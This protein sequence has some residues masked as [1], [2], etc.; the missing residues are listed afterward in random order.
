MMI[1][2]HMHTPRCGH[3]AGAPSE[4]VAAARR[5]GLEVIAFT[6][7]LALPDGYD[8]D[9]EYAMRPGELGD[10]VAEVRE[11]QRLSGHSPRVLL[12]IEAD[13]VPP[14]R[15]QTAR[16]IASH[17]F[18]VVLGSVHFLGDW[19]FDDPS[20]ID[21]WSLRDVAGA[22]DEYF[23]AFTHAAASG[24]FDVMA[25]PDLVKKFGHVPPGDL[26]ALYKDVAA[27]V[28]DAGVAVEVSS[29]GLRKPCREIYPSDAL[30][31]AFCRAGVPV[32][33]ASDAHTPEEVGSG[34]AEV[35][36]AVERAGY[37]SI[38]YF[39]AREM[40]EVPL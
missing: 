13:W 31:S 1:D 12:G 8:P 27:A 15:G 36:E 23:E 17:A 26:S 18:D 39:E 29:A 4:Y 20:L 34:L 37:S 11:V 24:L 7:H 10:Y 19:A 3:A 14:H 32:T 2:L 30:L 35:R 28:A 40:R 22:W 33:T 38:V 21:E 16:A 5:A 9:G 6:D 25:H